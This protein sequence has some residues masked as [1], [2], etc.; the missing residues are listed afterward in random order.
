MDIIKAGLAE[1]LFIKLQK[2]SL[3][4]KVNFFRLLAVSQRAGLGLRDSLVAIHASEHQR[5]MRVILTDLIDQLTQWV[6]LAGAMSNHPYFFA[7]DEVALV[8]SSELTGTM[9]D[10]LQDIALELENTQM[11][12]QKIMKA[13][14][15]PA[16]LVL[17]SFVAIVI[18]LIYVVP[19]IVSLFPEQSSLPSITLFVLHASAFVQTYWAI[20]LTILLWLV[21]L[22]RF[23]YVHILPFTMLIDKIVLVLPGISGVVKTF[24]MYRF[25]KLLSQFSQAGLNSVISLQLLQ[26]I[27]QNYYYKQKMYHVEQNIEN[28]FSFAESLEN[29]PLFDPILVQ[30]IAVWEKTGNVATILQSVSLYYHTLLDTKLSILMTLLEP[31]LMILVASLIG[32]IV[33]S[34]Y[35]PM[36]DLVNVIQ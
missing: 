3:K 28:G 20:W 4:T 5:W 29:S 7:A 32:V 14:T 23:A 10:V 15:Y 25:S 17:F 27:F 19:T 11:I 1:K 31:I 2:P 34:I 12:S 30:I 33:A 16:V 9:P 24:Y 8:R 35:L 6:G 22:V 18:L 26:Q 36:A 13:I 21:A